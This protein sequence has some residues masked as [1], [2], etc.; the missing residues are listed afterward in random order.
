LA[1]EAG[2]PL[3]NDITLNEICV[4]RTPFF[5]LFEFASLIARPSLGFAAFD[6][7]S[8]MARNSEQDLA[9]P[10]RKER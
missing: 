5:C 6:R 8:K 7:P 9:D 2:Y 4:N 10:D 1:K 3:E